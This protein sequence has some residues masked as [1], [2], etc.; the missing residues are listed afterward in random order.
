[1]GYN[2]TIGEAKIITY[3]EDGLESASAVG[4]KSIARYDAPS[5]GEPTDGTNERWVSYTSWWDFCEFVGLTHAIYDSEQRSLRG[6]HHGAFPINE[7]FK[8][9]V[10]AAMVRL[11]EKYPFAVA[12]YGENENDV[13]E[14][15]GAMCRLV[16]L[17]YWTN[18]ALDN[19][20]S[21]MF[22]NT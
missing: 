11:R 5:F 17:Q 8:K 3:T 4:A 21:P 18:Y 1:M 20:T 2:L 16:W 19:C 9:E 15:N 13:P 7:E 22:A 6:G 10:D 12:I 14:E